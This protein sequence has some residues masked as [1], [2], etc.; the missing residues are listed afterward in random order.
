M[1]TSGFHNNQVLKEKKIQIINLSFA[2]HNPFYI[3]LY[4][5][6]GILIFVCVCLCS[7]QSENQYNGGIALRKVGV[8]TFLGKV[9]IFRMSKTVPESSL[10]K[11][12]IRI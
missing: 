4:S 8:P 5:T 7:S 9:R 3:K 11:V 2:R 10:D 12:S 6:I 1:I